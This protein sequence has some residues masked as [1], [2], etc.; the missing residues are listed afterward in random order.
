[1]VG[2]P[3]V[4]VGVAV[5]GAGRV[6]VTPGEPHVVFENLDTYTPSNAPARDWKMGVV[7]R[8]DN[9]TRIELVVEGTSTLNL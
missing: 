4:T 9:T 6:G 5:A 7:G 1:M 3:G 2:P 8:L